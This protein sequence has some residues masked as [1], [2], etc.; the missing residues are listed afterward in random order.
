[1]TRKSS[2]DVLACLVQEY[3]VASSKVQSQK[4]VIR[5]YEKIGDTSPAAEAINNRRGQLLK[6]LG[7]LADIGAK[8]L[9]CIFHEPSGSC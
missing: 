1:M 7:H 4:T 6:E 3:K 9:A 8:A 2:Q 5:E